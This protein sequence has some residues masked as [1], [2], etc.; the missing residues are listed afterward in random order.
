MNQLKFYIKHGR[1]SIKYRFV[2]LCLLFNLNI[3]AQITID[4]IKLKPI[5]ITDVLEKMSLIKSLNDNTQMLQLS[6]DGGTIIKSIEGFSGI[7]RGG[8]NI[9]PVYRG[10]KNNQLN[11]II[12]DVAKIEGGCP[13]RM[14]PALSHIEPEEFAGIDIYR[15]SP[16]LEYFS[17]THG[18]I[19]MKTF[20]PLFAD[21][22]KIS[23]KAG[24]FYESNANGQKQYLHLGAANKQLYIKAF[25]AYKKF[26]NYQDGKYRTIPSSFAKYS[27]SGQL[28]YKLGNRFL[29]TA[30]YR[31]SHSNDVMFPALP[32]DED[33]D[34]TRMMYG[35]LQYYPRINFWKATSVQCY[36]SKVFHKMSN[37]FRENYI[38]PE[39]AMR[40]VT[41]VDALNYGAQ[42]KN[43]FY[44]KDRKIQ[45]QLALD[46]ETIE[47]S[48][49]RDMLMIMNQPGMPYSE[50]KSVTNLWNSAVIQNL[51]IYLSIEKKM[52]QWKLSCHS[53]ISSNY[54]YSNDTLK[55]IKDNIDY[56]NFSSNKNA[57]IDAG[58]LF[59]YVINSKVT[60][61]LNIGKYSRFPDMNERYIKLL[62]VGFDQFDY[63][64]NP[65]LKPETNY[66]IE[67]SVI[68]QPNKNEMLQINLFANQI[69]HYIHARL[70][71]PAVVKAQSMNVAGVK[72]F[73][74]ATT[75]RFLG[76]ELSLKKN[77]NKIFS[78]A[79]QLQYVYAYLTETP[80][81]LF[82]GKQAIG[83]T[84]L[85]NDPLPEIPP[86]EAKLEMAT[87]FTPQLF[88]TVQARY[89]APQ[90]EVSQAF[91]EVKNPDFTLFNFAVN[92]KINSQIS[93]HTAC[94]NI[95]NTAYYE[96]LN[97][98]IIGSPYKLYEPG[99]NFIVG[100]HCNF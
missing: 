26:G 19:N 5:T 24:A 97:R 20:Q 69:Q 98:R 90:N 81:I 23:G 66:Q 76:G 88:C 93:L 2:G 46:W 77:I 4:T 25:G 78:A 65:Q 50:S 60:N 53:R 94:H 84:L 36:H 56:F 12:D 41:V 1:L 43:E 83:D 48:G 16:A 11:Y 31:E 61:M 63:L 59:A 45:G 7:R 33:N 28:G 70:L 91:Y 57:T 64:G 87:Q 39:M 14:D 30:L 96:H 8:S 15:G 38:D 89:I 67:N 9:D 29:L 72:Q 37:R 58:L 52:R 92:Y 10:L 62:P 73:Y 68:I 18:I 40:A 82:K 86:F 27:Y 47:K 85:K 6:H 54:S 75:A 51:A 22:F 35:K 21:T 17:S 71:P 80:K 44:N 42:W 3:Y 74:N 79:L 13:N 99:R 100:L 55:I 32:M 49:E 34:D 95:F